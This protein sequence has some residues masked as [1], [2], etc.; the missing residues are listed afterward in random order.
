MSDRQHL[1]WVGSSEKG[2]RRARNEDAYAFDPSAGVAAVADGV[3]G[4]PGG[5]R[6]S[7]IAVDAAVRELAAAP[8]PDAGGSARRRAVDAAHRTVVDAWNEDPSLRG[9]A[10]TLTVVRWCGDRVEGVH[11]GDS[12]AYRMDRSGLE[13][14]THDHTPAG[15][16]LRRDGGD[17]ELLRTHPRRHLL[18]RVVGGDIDPPDPELFERE[19]LSPDAVLALCSDGVDAVMSESR[20][21]E[22]LAPA[23]AGELDEALRAV[24][25]DALGRGAPDNVTVVLGAVRRRSASPTG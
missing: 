4:G 24:L 3:G 21:A 18:L 14:L 19:G 16:V 22:L 13:P 1:D 9:M 6:A 17:R 12:R 11:V 10:S 15:E 23:L 8:W 7:R 5:D 20:L 2:P 25:A